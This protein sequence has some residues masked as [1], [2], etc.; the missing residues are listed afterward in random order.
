MIFSINVNDIFICVVFVIFEYCGPIQLDFHQNTK[1]NTFW[2]DIFVI[3]VY[4]LHMYYMVDYSA[5][6]HIF[7]TCNTHKTP[8]MY[9]RCNTIGYV[10]EFMGRCRKTLLIIILQL[11]ISYF[12]LKLA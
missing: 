4:S 12:L 5:V 11:V 8:H 1:V 2:I 9:Y 6:I 10:S 3:T 7:Y